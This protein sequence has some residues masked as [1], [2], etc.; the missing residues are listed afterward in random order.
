[1]S[2]DSF[3]FLNFE[4]KNKINLRICMRNFPLVLKIL[5][6]VFRL[7]TANWPSLD[8]HLGGENK[9]KHGN[10]IIRDRHDDMK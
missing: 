10:C 2:W 3:T 6:N 7:H 4:N 1:M 5:M 8:G 9:K